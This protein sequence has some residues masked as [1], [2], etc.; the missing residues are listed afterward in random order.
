MQFME[1]SII[2]LKKKLH[3]FRIT[4]KDVLEQIAKFFHILKLLYILF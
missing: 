3:G 2:L 1:K 4:H